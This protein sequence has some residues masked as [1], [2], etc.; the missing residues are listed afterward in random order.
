MARAAHRFVCG[1]SNKIGAQGVLS[2]YFSL[3][4]VGSHGR[5]DMAIGSIRYYDGRVLPCDLHRE[6]AAI[7]AN[8]LE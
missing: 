6:N 4:E 2:S 7:S 5:V 8:Y 1:V 3:T